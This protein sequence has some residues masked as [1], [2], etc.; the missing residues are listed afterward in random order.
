[1]TFPKQ[2]QL[3]LVLAH[4]FATDAFCQQ[5]NRGIPDGTEHGLFQMPC[6]LSKDWGCCV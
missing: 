2:P 6:M 4:L 5:A 1:M 3:L